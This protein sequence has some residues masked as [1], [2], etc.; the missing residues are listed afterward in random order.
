MRRTTGAREARILGLGEHRPPKVVTN[1]D[2]AESLDTNDAW[3][4]QRT[5]IASRR[6]AG[7]DETIVAM[8]AGAARKALAEAGV[9]AA[10]VG[11][12]TLA[13]CSMPSAIPGGAPQVATAIGAAGAGA[14]DLNA[15]CA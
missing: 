9:D 3:I 6:I 12:V 4:R 15:G 1:D 11:L 8:S 2:L 14:Y 5:G 13:T 7:D 10:R